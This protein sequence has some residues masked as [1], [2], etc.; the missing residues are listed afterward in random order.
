MGTN[1]YW[2]APVK[3]CECCKQPVNAPDG[4]P[5][6]L[7]IGKSSAGWCFMVHTHPE[8]G[9][10]NL[11]DWI[12]K[13]LTPGSKI[14]DEYKAEVTVEQ[15]LTTIMLRNRI[16]PREIVPAGYS[17]W[18]QFHARNDSQFGPNDMLRARIGTLCVAHGNGPWDYAEREFS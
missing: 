16:T 18:S 9:I 4:I 5:E 3:V 15:M 11:E 10:H 12:K 1:Y 6:P 7:H 2:H 13:M 14:V 8:L 17:S